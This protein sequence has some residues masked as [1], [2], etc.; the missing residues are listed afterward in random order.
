MTRWPDLARVVHSGT[1]TPFVEL[2]DARGVLGD[3]VPDAEMEAAV[4]RAASLV[5]GLDSRTRRLFRRD[6]SIVARAG[7]VP[8]ES[9]PLALP[10]I[11]GAVDVGRAWTTKSGVETDV[12]GSAVVGYTAG[13]PHVYHRMDAS[14]GEPDFYEVEYSVASGMAVPADIKS[15][16][17]AIAARLLE[18]PSLASDPRWREQ[19]TWSF[20]LSENAIPRRVGAV[21]GAQNGP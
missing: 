21:E 18:W 15:V 19:P 2:A 12:T 5:E 20:V 7:A 10:G 3:D 1:T 9:A 14:S 4:E 11:K 8:L 16:C 13:L 17:L 6:A